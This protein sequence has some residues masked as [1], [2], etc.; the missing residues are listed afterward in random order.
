MGSCRARASTLALTIMV[1]LTGCESL[2]DPTPPPEATTPTP[3]ARTVSGEGFTTAVAPGW[4][5]RLGDTTEVLQF[6]SGGKPIL[7]IERPP[8]GEVRP[9]VNDVPSSIAIVRLRDRIP[10]EKV[11][12]YLKNFPGTILAAPP[13]HYGLGGDEGVLV[14][15]THGLRGTPV[16]TLDMVVTHHGITHEVFFTAAVQD[17]QPQLADA[18]QVIDS[19]LWQDGP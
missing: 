6:S 19:W 1:L 7:L 2:S 5:N 9:N 8:S 15:Y 13:R 3:M 12:T 14:V 16:E 11:L 18:M 10:D 4:S 17:Y